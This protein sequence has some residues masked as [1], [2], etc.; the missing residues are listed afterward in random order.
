MRKMTSD[1]GVLF[2]FG[3]TRL[4]QRL[5]LKWLFFYC[6]FSQTSTKRHTGW[7]NQT[8]DSKS[9]N[10]VRKR[11]TNYSLNERFQLVG[12][13]A[14]IPLLEFMFSHDK[15]PEDT[16]ATDANV[17]IKNTCVMYEYKMRKLQWN[18]RQTGLN[19]RWWERA[20][21]LRFFFW[22]PIRALH[23]SADHTRPWATFIC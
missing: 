18:H 14:W 9:T 5:C 15:Q 20:A 17:L 23:L 4:V 10:K 3:E 19:G 6:K 16:S 21:A 13:H 12:E 22:Q 11:R 8:Q 7:F 1:T 2:I